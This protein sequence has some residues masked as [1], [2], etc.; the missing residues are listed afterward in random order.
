MNKPPRHGRII[1]KKAHGQNTSTRSVLKTKHQKTEILMYNY[2]YT[3]TFSPES[4]LAIERRRAD[5]DIFG[6]KYEKRI[7]LP[8]TWEHVRITSEGGAKSINRPMGCYDTLNVGRLDTLGEDALLD[9]QEEIARR[10]IQIFDDVAV[11]PARILVVGLGNASLTPDSVGPKSAAKIKPT[12]HIRE[13]DEELF[14]SLECSELAVLSPTVPAISGMDTG[15][16]VK[17]VCEA[18][19]PDAVIAIDSLVTSSKQRLGTTFQISDAGIF[20][21]GFGNLKTPITRSGVGVPVIGIG[22][23][24]VMDSRLFTIHS[25]IDC[26]EPMFVSPREIDEITDNASSV[27]AGAINQAFG[28]YA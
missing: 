16:T 13:Y 6:V 8:G 1:S 10:L 11:T 5:T 12:M 25:A 21:G 18:I 22:V 24:T 19:V 4:D 2:R 20:P 17:A 9:V 14:D 28:L 27:I 23:P 15:R 7:C 3:S 26:D